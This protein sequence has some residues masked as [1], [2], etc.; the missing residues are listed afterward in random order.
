M[1]VRKLLAVF[2]LATVSHTIHTR[3]LPLCKKEH[4]LS[5]SKKL[6]HTLILSD[7][8]SIAN[9]SL[10]PWDYVIYENKNIFPSTFL[11]AKCREDRCIDPGNFNRH[12]HLLNSVPINYT[13]SVYHREGGET[14]LYCL[15]KK[16]FQITV[17]CT[18][19]M[20]KN[21]VTHK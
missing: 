17:G 1:H 14:D 10:S 13:I 2:I 8:G 3:S 12:N 5:N 15:R 20:A 4:D 21:K 16:S 11:M 7:L 9:R 6:K 19:V 18:C